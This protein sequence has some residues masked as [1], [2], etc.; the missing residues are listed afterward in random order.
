MLPAKD[1]LKICFAL[2]AKRLLTM[3]SW[4]LHNVISH[5][6]LLSADILRT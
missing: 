2:R 6:L 3:N 4:L 5:R 1:Q